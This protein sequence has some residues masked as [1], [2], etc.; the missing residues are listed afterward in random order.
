LEG[1]A[2]MASKRGLEYKFLIST[3]FP[4]EMGNLELTD[5][6]KDS[7][8][9]PEIYYSVYSMDTAFRRKWIPKAI[10]PYHALAKL[11][12]WQE[13]TGKTPKIHYA[14]IDGQNDSLY[15]VDNII[16]AIE[17]VQ[18]K[19]NWNV[20]RYNPPEGHDSRETP[21]NRIHYI[22]SFIR[23]RLHCDAKVKVIPRVGID[24]K[25]SCG[26]FLN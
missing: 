22:A 10:N 5:I 3:I 16:K 13:T 1:L 8:L 14:F 6:F 15:T 21:E 7:E 19:V 20:V 9:Y 18:L 12:Y 24:V 17:Q 25:A 23:D 26:T 2:E 11:Q 4:K